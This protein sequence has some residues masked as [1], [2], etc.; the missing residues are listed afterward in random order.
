EHVVAPVGLPLIDLARVDTGDDASAVGEG[1]PH[2]DERIGALEVLGCGGPGVAVPDP[3]R[4]ARGGGRGGPGG[5]QRWGERV[6]RGRG[7]VGEEPEPGLAGRCAGA[8]APAGASALPA[9]ALRDAG[10][11]LCALGP[12]ALDGRAADVAGAAASRAA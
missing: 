10:E 9:Q 6:R 8:D 11:V 12:L 2:V 7:A 4:A 5:L 3:L 1:Q